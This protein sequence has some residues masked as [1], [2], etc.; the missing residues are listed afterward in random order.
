[1]GA[2]F[3]QLFQLAAF[4]LTPHVRMRDRQRDM[5]AMWEVHTNGGKGAGI[6]LP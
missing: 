2:M 3:C 6:L 4:S 5:E 1:M